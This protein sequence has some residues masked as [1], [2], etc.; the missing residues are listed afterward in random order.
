MFYMSVVLSSLFLYSFSFQEAQAMK[1]DEYKEEFEGGCMAGNPDSVQ[2]KELF[3]YKTYARKY[4]SSDNGDEWRNKLDKEGYSKGNTG[5]NTL[6]IE[7]NSSKCCMNCR[8]P[9]DMQYRNHFSSWKLDNAPLHCF[10]YALSTYGEQLEKIAGQKMDDIL[11]SATTGIDNVISACFVCVKG[12]PE[13]GDLVVYQTTKEVQVPYGQKIPAGINT[14]AGIFR[15]N[16]S[17][18]IHSD[19]GTVESQWGSNLVCS[20]AY[21]TSVFFTYSY[22]GDL[23]KFYR[24]RTKPRITPMDIGNLH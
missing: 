8:M 1:S 17:K 11:G 19:E 10:A 18:G 3:N 22:Y 14:H 5:I 24:L 4:E 15:V 13:D 7:Y 21:K 16:K 2:S 23:A 6:G 20:Y 12:L 9:T